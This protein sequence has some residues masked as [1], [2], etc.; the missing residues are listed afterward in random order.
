MK[1]ILDGVVA[2]SLEQAVAAPYCSR[3]L[4]DSG[5]RVIKVERPEGDFARYYDNVVHHNS[6]YFC[7]LNAGKESICIDLTDS[8]D[9]S[10]LKSMIESA[11]IF[12][13]NLKPGVTEKYSLDHTSNQCLNP[14]L[15]TCNISGYG[16]S[17][18]Y[19]SMK[20]YDALIQAETGLCSVT[21]PPET[22]S[23]VGASICDISTGLTAYSEILK[24][25]Y[26]R[27][28]SKKGAE[29]NVSLFGVLSEWM[30]VPLAYY[31]YGNKI[32]QGTG[33]DHGQL[34]PYGQFETKTGPIFLV[35]QSDREWRRFCSDVLEAK[36]VANDK[37]FITNQQRMENLILL[38]QIINDTLRKSTR[39]EVIKKLGVS[40]IAYGSVNSV[41]ELSEHP[42][43]VRREIR[44]NNGKFITVD[45]VGN[46][47]NIN[48][49]I[50]ELNEHGSLIR[51]EFDSKMNRGDE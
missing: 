5:A 4:S 18:K 16:Q 46:S 41:K 21:G 42:A 37:R 48:I 39:E 2:I 33:L 15:I 40:Q 23:K 35:I 32:P 27:E 28:A 19:A 11:D 22:P 7:W 34:A 1:N 3:L 49:K 25:L 50:P 38:K 20:A 13:Q 8:K 10:L 43:L 51:K 47:K 45:H 29:I 24:Y 17:G 6:A 30:S 12:I 36:D 9:L 44:T 14:R 31:E 26:K